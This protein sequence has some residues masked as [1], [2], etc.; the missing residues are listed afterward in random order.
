[1]AS[2]WSRLARSEQVV[3]A[4]IETASRPPPRKAIERIF[5][6]RYE[7]HV[8]AP[9]VLM[10][11][12]GWRRRVAELE[13]KLAQVTDERDKL[14]R[15]YEQLKEQLELLKRRIY[16][17]RAER[18]DVAQLELEFAQKKAELELLARVL[19]ET[20][21]D[22]SPG[23]GSSGNDAPASG[24][25]GARPKG[26][27]NLGNETM[28]EERVEITDPALEGHAERIGFEESYRL[29]YRRGGPVRIV[30]ARATYKTKDEAGNVSLQTAD[31]PKEL[32]RRGLL[33]PSFVAHILVAKYRFGLPFN[34]QSKM[35]DAEGVALDDGTMC[36]YAEEAGASLGAIVEA[37]AAEARSSA[38]CLATDAT[39]VAIRPEPLAIGG[40]QACKKG[41]FFVVLADRDHVFFEYTEKHTSK[42][43]C[44]LF[45]GFGG[46]LLADAHCVYDALYRGDAR[47]EPEDKPPSEVGCWAHCR[48]KFWE[49]AVT[50][51][52]PLAREG[53]LRIRVLFE[54]DARWAALPPNQR[55]DK[56]QQAARPLI[57]DFFAWVRAQH[58]T[59]GQTRS[60]LAS[61]FG[62]AVRQEIAL[63]RFLDDGRLPLTNNASERALRNIAVGRKNW[64]FFGSDDHATAAANLFSLIASCQLHDLDAETY[65]AEIFRVLPYWPRDRFLELA[66]KYWAATR[67]RLRDDELARPVGHIT[68]PP[69]SEQ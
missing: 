3:R 64:L 33:A 51:K 27:R 38:F 16:F 12:E 35:L 11:E 45:R 14:R 62:Y 21:N 69:A 67:A 57:D 59:A 60:L 32:F 24:G 41:H 26:R 31:K 25:A 1:M 5:A 52:E 43:V 4:C 47:E 42:A 58:A 28:V 54:L 50:T 55:H 39:G 40:R 68:V 63:R 44:D 34:R 49:A 56:R 23:D 61:A 48:R 2:T 36:R 46:Y 37:C 8:H 7:A 29:G 30:V 66:P 17:A 22:G 13:A 53:L 20:S 65:L 10:P 19:D 6:F 9:A 15:A 18:V